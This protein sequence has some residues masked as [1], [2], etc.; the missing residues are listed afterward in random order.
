M[1][2][3]FGQFGQSGQ[4]NGGTETNGGSRLRSD[5]IGRAVEILHHRGPDSHGQ[6]RS[7]RFQMGM[8]RLAIIDPAAGQQPIASPD[9]RTQV[10]FNGEIYN[11]RQLRAELEPD[12]RFRTHSDTEVIL[13]GYLKWGRGVFKRLNGIFAIAVWNED[14]QSLL[15]ARDP[16]GIKPLYIRDDGQSV[17]FSSELK[18]LTKLGIANTLSRTA[19]HQFLLTGYVHH[20]HTAIEGVHQ[21][22]PGC[23][24]HFDRNLKRTETSF[25]E[26]LRSRE[27]LRKDQVAPLKNH[28]EIRAFVERELEEAVLRQTVSDVPI[29][30]LLSSGLDSMVILDIL[31]RK[32]F[33]RDLSTFTVGFE[34]PSFSEDRLVGD[35]CHK[36]GIRN[37]SL[38]ISSDYF[39]NKFEDVCYHLDNLE[40]LPTNMGI[41]AVSELA[42]KSVK[43]A[44]SGNGG[45]ELFFGYPTYRASRLLSQMPWLGGMLNSL[46]PLT[47]R[48]PGS[49]RYLSWSEKAKRFT[50]YARSSPELSHLLW[51]SVFSAR[52]LR[53]LLPG[54]AGMG[55]AT[56][57]TE[58]DLFA[59]QLRFFEEARG[60][61]FEGLDVFMYVDCKT[62]L[63][64]CGQ[65]MWDK[66]GMRSSLEIRVPF[67]DLEFFS[68]ITSLPLQNRARKLGS[69]DLLRQIARERLPDSIYRQ[70]KRGF[71]VPVAE[72]LR[73]DLYEQFRDYTRMLPAALVSQAQ[74]DR[75]W[76]EHRDGRRDHGLKLWLLASLA[77]WM[78]LHDVRIADADGDEVERNPVDI[79]AGKPM[80]TGRGFEPFV[81]GAMG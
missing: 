57:M 21:V 62:W 77:V 16:I 32:G 20:P 10:I 61:G 68:A 52:E 4:S 43:V 54:M 3:I 76:S 75:L 28:G 48:L 55:G 66:A 42:G 53:T 46:A 18:L 15:L 13:A 5:L 27:D 73:T 14:E 79:A 8:V 19:L 33:D 39:K 36:L 45:D 25:T 35:A 34:N 24:I 44:L 65:C 11:Y 70:R 64:D 9:G 56:E 6:Y 50:A 58:T 67:L 1:C 37:E 2:G 71:Q 31:R 47:E 40:F 63:M 38:R 74:V 80:E 22:P 60:L 30:L 7:S 17:Y 41:F 12:Y 72:Y 26:F 23:L 49:S 59:S 29:G 81:T 69:K 78:R 51:R